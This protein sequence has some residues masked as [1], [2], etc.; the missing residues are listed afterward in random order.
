[1]LPTA[2]VLA[3]GH[4]AVDDSVAVEEDGLQGG[5]KAGGLIYVLGPVLLGAFWLDVHPAMIAISGCWAGTA[6]GSSRS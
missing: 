2:D 6:P 1:M 5:A 4:L 3:L